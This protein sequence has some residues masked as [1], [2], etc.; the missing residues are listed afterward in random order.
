V[1]S[2]FDEDANLLGWGPDGIYF[3]ATQTTASHIFRA[4]P[5]TRA[6][7]R[8][9]GPDRFLVSGASFTK[10]YRTL[11]DVGAEPNRSADVYVSST[12][13]FTSRRLTDFAAQW[14][15]FTLAFE[16]YQALKD[17][18]MP[19]KL[20]LYKGFGHPINKPKQQAKRQK[21]VMDTTTI[22]SASTSR[23]KTRDRTDEGFCS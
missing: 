12:S 2:E 9:S 21:A 13:D 15:D 20:V 10:D 5:A 1:T 6:V 19:V 8:I 3:G 22:G 7:R 16:L 23:A 11:A 14:K 4:G 17:R 18:N